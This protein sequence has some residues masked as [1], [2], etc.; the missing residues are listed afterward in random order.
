MHSFK[1]ERIHTLC[2]IKQKGGVKYLPKSVVTM[3][4]LSQSLTLLQAKI[5]YE[6]R[7]IWTKP[8]C[9]QGQLGLVQIVLCGEFGLLTK[10]TW[11]VMARLPDRETDC[12][13]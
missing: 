1:L 4:V 12:G 13:S 10:F 11:S 5:P 9:H 3:T 6:T 7:L 8:K 2:T